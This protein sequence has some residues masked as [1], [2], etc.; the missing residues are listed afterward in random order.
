M[1]VLSQHPAAL[2]ACGRSAHCK[3]APMRRSYT[4]TRGKK[5]QNEPRASE[6][7]SREAAVMGTCLPQPILKPAHGQALNCSA[8]IKLT[9]GVAPSNVL[10]LGLAPPA[11]K[12]FTTATAASALVCVPTQCCWGR[13]MKGRAG[14]QFGSSCRFNSWQR[15]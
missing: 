3:C 4:L 1:P 11:T 9:S 2:A 15:W 12:A 10:A 8:A 5:E 14:A 7:E 13:A 6:A